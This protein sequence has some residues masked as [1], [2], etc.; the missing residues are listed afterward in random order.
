MVNSAFKTVLICA[1]L[2][3][4]AVGQTAGQYGQV[5]FGWTF[6]DRLR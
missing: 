6:F 5:N 1:A 2:I 3:G 4:G